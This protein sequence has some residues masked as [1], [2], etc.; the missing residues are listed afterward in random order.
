M[1][2]GDGADINAARWLIENDELRQLR[3]RLGDDDFLLISARQFDDPRI[4]VDRFNI[5]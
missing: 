3:E 2:F 4:L 1:D 5:E